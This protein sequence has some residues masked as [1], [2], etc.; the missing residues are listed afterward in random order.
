MY[1]L[2]VKLFLDEFLIDSIIGSLLLESWM[3]QFRVGPG[4]TDRTDHKFIVWEK[5]YLKYS[6]F[7]Q[8]RKNLLTIH[9]WCCNYF[10]TFQKIHISP[11]LQRPVKICFNLTV[12]KINV[13]G[14]VNIQFLHKSNQKSN[15]KW[16]NICWIQFKYPTIKWE[17]TV[18]N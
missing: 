9:Q 5:K 7:S 10:S 14:L 18:S 15:L 8:I 6:I 13:C 12:G 2:S 11:I 16:W 4:W 17:Q 3:L 1:R